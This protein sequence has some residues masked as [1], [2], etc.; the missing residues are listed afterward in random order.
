MEKGKLKSW[1]DS[2]GF[3]FVESDSLNRDI[4]IH[5]SSL[6]AMSRKPK[7]GDFIYFE[8]QKQADGKSRAINCRIEGVF[9]LNPQ[10]AQKVAEPKRTVISNLFSLV[11][12]IGIANF[13]YIYIND[14]SVDT[15]IINELEPVAYKRVF[16]ETVHVKA[17]NKP[18]FIFPEPVVYNTKTTNKAKFTPSEKPR[19]KCDGRQHCSQMTSRSEA[20]FFT[21]N[22][23]NTKMD[24]DHDGIPCENDSR[25]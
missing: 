10:M 23:P 19:F 2:R 18:K 22:C 25:F 4:F 5:I 20:N 12:F 17:T 15:E 11:V 21:A 8:V 24:G 16:K 3:G 13:V 1:N 7:V 14:D 6:K 9:A